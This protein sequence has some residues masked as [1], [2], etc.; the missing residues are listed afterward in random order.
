MIDA[1]IQSNLVHEQ[2]IRGDSTVCWRLVGKSDVTF[3]SSIPVMQVAHSRGDVRCCDKVFP[4]ADA[5]LGNRRMERNREKTT[6]QCFQ[7]P[8]PMFH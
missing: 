3:Y 8:A 7:S 6:C 5:Q 4:M 1:G 2:D